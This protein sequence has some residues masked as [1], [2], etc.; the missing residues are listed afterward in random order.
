MHALLVVIAMLT[1]GTGPA[2]GPVFSGRPLAAWLAELGDADVLVREEALEVLAR[3]GPAAKETV[4][5]LRK[6]LRAEP[7]TLRVR[8]ALALGRITGDNGPAAT[9]LAEYLRLAPGTATRQHALQQLQQLGPDGVA[10]A[11]AVLELTEHEDLSLRN[12]AQAV[13]TAMGPR[14]VPA[15]VT[16]LKDPQVQRRRQAALV[17]GRMG[18][19]AQDAAAALEGRLTDEDRAVRVHSARVLW[20]LGKSTEAVAGVL[21]AAV[22]GDDAELRHEALDTVT[23]FV[24]ARRRPLVRPILEAAL[25]GDDA[26]TRM[27]AA[28]ALYALDGKA[29][30]VLPVLREGLHSHD[31]QVW[32]QAALA[33]AK[34]GPRAAPAVADLVALL[35]GLQGGYGSELQEALVQ[36]GPAAVGPVAALLTEPAAT[37]QLIQGASSVLERMGP[38]AAPKVGPLLGHDNFQVRAAAC[39]VLGHGGRAAK[40]F[41]TA[42]ADRLQDSQPMVRQAALEAF[43]MLGPQGRGATEAVLNLAQDPQPFTRLQALMTLE[44]MGAEPDKARP[45]VLAALKD[46]IPMVRA[47]ALATLAV[48]DPHCPDVVPRARELLQDPATKAQALPVIGRMG[49]AAGPL[50]PVLVEMLRREHNVVQR[51][52]LATVLGQVGPAAREAVPELAAMMREHDVFA[53]QVA[54]TAL[55]AIGGGDAKAVPPLVEAL[56]AETQPFQRSR[57]M[58]LL[59]QYGPAAA[60]AADLLLEE[61]KRPSWMHQ[62]Q[63]AAALARIAP[64]RARKEGVPLMEKWLTKDPYRMLAAGALCRMDPT[65]KAAMAAV[66]QALADTDAQRSY[67]RQQAADAVG[68]IGPAAKDAAADLRAALK[69]P[70]PGVRFSAAVAL[71]QV[72]GKAD[73]AVAVLTEGLGGGER[74]WRYQAVQKLGVMGPA[75]RSAVPALLRLEDDP[76]RAL[77]MMATTALRKIDSAAAGRAGLP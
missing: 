6:L 61:L 53:R 58:E 67:Q 62:A 18:P 27:R 55:L 40:P 32:S 30:A 3:A 29:E 69:A 52:Q 45:V 44:Q 63:A 13:L 1:A 46:S 75:A 20:G 10:A 76:D 28:G 23:G 56:R 25:R 71:W 35:K 26:A 7:V 49:T 47:Q 50:A 39:R 42:L 16:A 38:A 37:P 60:P 73:E 2:D 4:P 57:L 17:L 8:A 51:R 33:L 24:D 48:V 72:T 41:V 54:L 14:A 31:R 21:A 77:R 19:L 70:Q 9:A 65:H 15:L 64:E 34:L 66:R 43:R 11:A 68:A 36:A 5:Q 74:V 22:R 12:H 59:G